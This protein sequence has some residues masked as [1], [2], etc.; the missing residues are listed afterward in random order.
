MDEN[1]WTGGTPKHLKDATKCE[2]D[3]SGV[4][5]GSNPQIDPGQTQGP[6]H[7]RS[8]MAQPAAGTAAGFPQVPG[9]SGQIRT[10][11]N[12]VKHGETR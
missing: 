1:A 3:R 6:S 11:K 10:K 9:Y 5:P 7:C 2:P 12:T 4:N 8:E